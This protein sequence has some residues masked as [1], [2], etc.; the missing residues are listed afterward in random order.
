MKKNAT[1][2]LVLFLSIF[3]CG[4]IKSQQNK[5]LNFKENKGQVCDQFY[6]PRVDILFSGNAGDMTFYLKNTGVSYQLSRV[7]KW[8]DKKNSF[9]PGKFMGA[10]RVPAATT[11][12]RLDIDWVGAVSQAQILTGKSLEGYDNYYLASCPNGALNVRSFSDVIYKNIYPG[13]DLKWYEKNGNLKYDYYVSGNAD[14]KKIQLEYKGAEKIYVNGTGELIIETPL[15]MLKEQAPLVTQGNRILHGKWIIK[16]NRVSFDIKNINSS[17]PFIIDPMIRLWGTYYGGSGDEWPSYMHTNSAGDLFVG[18][19]TSSSTNIATIGAHQVT[20]AG[21]AQLYDGYLVKFNSAGVRQWATYYGGTGDDYTGKSVSDPSGNVYVTGRSESGNPGVIATSGAHQTVY[22]STLGPGDAFL[23]KFNSAG[24]RQW[25]TYYGGD[26]Q[27]YGWGIAR[28]N[29][30]DIYISGGSESTTGISTPGCYQPT[31]AGVSDGFIAKFS[32]AGV[33]IWG[34]Y[35]GGASYDNLGDCIMSSTGDLYI[36][37]MTSSTAGVA[38]PGSH[39]SVY[40]GGPGWGGDLL[41]IKMN[42]A[43]I[44]QWA[45]YYGGPGTDQ[46]SDLATDAAGN[47]YGC[48]ICG[49]SSGTVIATLGSHQANY[50]GGTGDAFL[51][52]FDPAGVRQWATYYGGNGTDYGVTPATDGA[53]NVYLS[54]IAGTTTGTIIATKCS[55]QDTYGG[56]SQ[57]GYLAKFSSAGVRIWGSYY[58]SPFTDNVNHCITDLSGNVFMAGNTL[59][60]SGTLMASSNGYQPIY[61]GGP[62]DVY[63]A[64][65]DGCIPGNISSLTPPANLFVCEGN[66]TTLST[67][68]GNWYNT[69][70]GTVVLSSGGTFTAGPIVSDSTFY[71]EDFGCGSITGT[72]TAVNVT[73]SPSPTLT[74]TNSNPLACVNESVILTVSGASTYSW[75]NNS[76][77]TPSIQLIAFLNT[78]YTVNGIDANGCQSTAMLAVVPNLCL[79][80]AGQENINSHLYIYPNPN[81]GAFTIQ[82]GSNLNLTLTNELGQTLRTLALTSVNDFNVT[83][84]DLPNGIY[85]LKGGKENYS[86]NKKIIVIH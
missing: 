73:L 14:Y 27:E 68:C 19:G 15:G 81:N 31:V 32:P 42:Q 7:D 49:P 39:Q 10:E 4:A 36:C 1:L 79:G 52:K 45:T 17:L 66:T 82:S 83:L 72:R 53:G 34:T 18:G 35:Y 23:V 75:I 37:G 20:F 28:D 22:T 70:T 38:T 59:A 13:I 41:F 62:S 16:N 58:G 71:L 77:S 60:N 30:G 12:Y 29:S 40:G 43:G 25:G 8:E 21:P 11:L 6:K 86:F 65:F 67:T 44:P 47:I 54:G 69:A 48:G 63:I 80:I 2:Q 5:T 46:G 56:G 78:T 50:G 85:F 33:R 64:K 74:V 3:C 76:A 9:A 51:V 61:G 57:D 24:I 55:Y 26:A 84:N